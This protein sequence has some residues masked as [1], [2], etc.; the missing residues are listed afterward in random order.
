MS[1]DQLQIIEI[2]EV[3][4]TEKARR[5]FLSRTMCAV[6]TILITLFAIE[7]IFRGNLPVAMVLCVFSITNLIA[8]MLYKHF[9]NLEV[10]GYYLIASCGGLCLYLA[11]TGGTTNSG[12]IWAPAFPVLMFSTQRT[13]TATI[14]VFT[15]LLMIIA[16]I[17]TPNFPYYQ[18]SYNPFTKIASI[19]CYLLVAGFTLFQE[20]AREVSAYSVSELTKRLC[21]IASTDELTSL[22]NRRDMVS[23]LDFECR[24]SRRTDQEFSVIL[25]DIDHFKKI[26]DSFGHSVGDQALQAFSNILTERFRDTD[27][28]GRWGGE[29]FLIILPHTALNE[30]IDLATKVRKNVCQTSLLANMPNRLVTMSAGVASSKQSN[31]AGELVR[32]ADKNLYNAK[33]SGRN[34]VK[35]DIK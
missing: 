10:F 28:V 3:Q 6:V 15:V 7:D 27:K 18:A 31:D 16:I 2:E 25:C 4:R 21:H 13:K 9:H 24:R 19:G 35:P 12:I 33:N 8:I 20:R 17:Y 32:L 29:E 5:D 22:P 23:R 30:A 26:N 1:L 14:A 34:R 11:A